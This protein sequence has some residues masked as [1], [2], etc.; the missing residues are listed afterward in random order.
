MYR[1]ATTTIYVRVIQLKRKPGLCIRRS[2]S[3]WGCMQVR[4][5]GYRTV[6]YRM[7]T[8]T[9]VHSTSLR[10]HLDIC[11]DCSCWDADIHHADMSDLWG[12]MKN[13]S[14]NSKPCSL[15]WY[16]RTKV[17][18]VGPCFV[19]TVDSLPALYC[20]LSMSSSPDQTTSSH[21]SIKCA[22]LKHFGYSDYWLFITN[23]LLI[24]YWLTWTVTSSDSLFT[25]Q[26]YW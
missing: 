10:I 22:V 26:I 18:F 13:R 4:E 17:Q 9:T 16:L 11:I 15:S 8:G 23:L 20:F 2:A 6:S 12:Q 24:Y 7:S 5:A 21:N 3:L 1:L 19:D 14:W 25:I